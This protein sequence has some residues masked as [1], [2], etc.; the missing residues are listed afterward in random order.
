MGEHND[1]LVAELNEPATLRCPAGG[2]PKPIVTWWRETFM[3]PIKLINRDYSLQFT[4]VRLS[5]LGPYVCQAYSGAGKG[6]SRTVTLKAYGPVPFTDPVDEKY[7]RYIV[8]TR[9][10]HAPSYRPQ[11]PHY[12]EP[13]APPAIVHTP[14][15]PPV[16][17]PAPGKSRQSNSQ[18]FVRI[19]NVTNPQNCPRNHPT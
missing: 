14:A 4:R 15:P 18:R 9:P 2:Y 13:T 11:P 6:I 8:H 12:P 7:L 19:S 16:Y 3:M 5:D 17:V 10:A 1:T